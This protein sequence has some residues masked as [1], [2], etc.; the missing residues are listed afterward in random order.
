MLA[1]LASIEKRKSDALFQNTNW[2]IGKRPL[3]PLQ[4]LELNRRGVAD[5]QTQPVWSCKRSNSTGVGLQTL[6]LNQ[7][8]YADAKAQ[9][10]WGC[11]RSNST[12]VWLQTLKLN[13]HGAADAQTQRGAWMGLAKAGL[14]SSQGGGRYLGSID[15]QLCIQLPCMLARPGQA[16]MEGNPYCFDKQYGFPVMQARPTCGPSLDWM[17]GNPYFLNQ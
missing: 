2:Y 7:C 16:H 1:L 5:A 4:P 15:I 3:L 8:G 13:R 17:I 14:L 6:K 9:P 12:G 11:R 10:A